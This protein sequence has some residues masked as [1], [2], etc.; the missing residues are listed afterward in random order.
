MSATNSTY[1]KTSDTVVLAVDNK[2]DSS[3]ELHINVGIDSSTVDV[4]LDKND[5]IQL[6][7][8]LSTVLMDYG[9]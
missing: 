8:H 5:I 6:I 7:Q 9:L 4:Y 2:I 3:G 1:T